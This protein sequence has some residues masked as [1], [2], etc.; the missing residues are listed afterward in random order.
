MGQFSFLLSEQKLQAHTFKGIAL[1]GSITSAD[2]TGRWKSPIHPAGEKHCHCQETKSSP[3]TPCFHLRISIVWW[4]V[5][6]LIA[7]TGL[8]VSQWVAMVTRK[9][10]AQTRQT[11]S[12]PPNNNSPTIKA[13]KRA[14]F[15]RTFIPSNFWASS[16][17]TGSLS[18][19]P[20]GKKHRE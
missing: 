8:T 3:K 11:A 14:K 12:Q 1:N 20:V 10:G 13:W 4:W 19:H 5:M 16:R 2:E 9:A 15:C 7:Q 17:T 6:S 18:F